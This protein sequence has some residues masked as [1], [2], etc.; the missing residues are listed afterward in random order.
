VMQHPPTVNY[1][2]TPIFSLLSDKVLIENRHNRNS[3]KCLRGEELLRSLKGLPTDWID[4]YSINI[5]SRN[6]AP[7]SS[8]P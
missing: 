1:V 5:G 6:C 2:E 4:I 7:G 3:R 8:I